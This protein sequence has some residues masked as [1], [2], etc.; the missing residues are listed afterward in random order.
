MFGHRSALVAVI[1]LIATAAPASAATLHL[2]A[3]KVIDRAEKFRVVASGKAKPQ[4][5]YYVSVIYHDDDQGRCAPTVVKEVTRNEYFA[6]F[7]RRKVVTDAEGRFELSRKVVG[8]DRR[9]SGKF[10]GYLTN[11][12]DENKDTVVRRIE[13]T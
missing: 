6:V 8:G 10:C 13:F 3:P 2:Q 11:R 5:D 1:A 4:R 9:T 12:D 7:F